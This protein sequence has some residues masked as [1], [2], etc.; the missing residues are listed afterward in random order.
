MHGPV[1]GV[2]ACRVGRY[3]R[4]VMQSDQP[5]FPYRRI[6]DDLRSAILTGQFAPGER[7]ASEWKLAQTYQASRPTVRRAIA[8]LKGDGLVVTRQ[9]QGAFVRSLPLVRLRVTGA[10]YRR[11]RREGVPGFNAQVIEQGQRPEQRLLATESIGALEEVANH[12]GLDAG[13]A[14]IVRRRLFLVN[15]QP[16]ARCDSYYPLGMVAGTQ[17]AENVR[18]RGGVLSYIENPDGPIRRVV[19][20]S[21]DELSA[22]MPTLLEAEE[23]GLASGVP[24]VRILRTVYDIDDTPIEFQESIASADRHEFHYEVNMQ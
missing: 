15:D 12:L 20:R 16:V 9:G 4:W 5:G 10:D 2:T 18:I 1:L 23:L 21:V 19:A 24:V 22:R 13:A 3:G 6:I 11:H 7:L 14:V 8:V 17:I